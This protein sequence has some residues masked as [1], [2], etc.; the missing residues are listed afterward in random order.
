[1][2]SITSD[3]VVDY[4]APLPSGLVPS[5]SINT[6]ATPGVGDDGEVFGLA[7][8]PPQ[9]PSRQKLAHQKYM[10]SLI[11]QPGTRKDGKYS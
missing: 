10:H 11:K 4:N 3:V 2:A 9:S 7:L 1:M 6:L 8:T 5:P